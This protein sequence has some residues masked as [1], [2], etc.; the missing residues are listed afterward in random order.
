MEQDR[1]PRRIE[2]RQDLRTQFPDNERAETYLPMFL[3]GVHVAQVEVDMETGL[4]RVLSVSA[5]HD[6]GRVINRRDT[7]GQIEGSIVMGMGGVLMEEFVP[8]LSSGFSNYMIPTCAPRRKSAC[9]WSRRR[10]VTGRW[11]PRDSAKPRCCRPPRRWSTR[12]RAPSARGCADCRQRQSACSRRSA[13]KAG[14][15]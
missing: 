15:R 11:A 13:T 9:I 6:V 8:G 12:S 3:T 5:A 7:E 1:V 2:G 14:V 10:A 4:T